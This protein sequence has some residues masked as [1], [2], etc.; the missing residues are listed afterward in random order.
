MISGIARNIEA[1]ERIRKIF[2]MERYVLAFTP[3]EEIGRGANKFDV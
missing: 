3:D 1:S 2:H